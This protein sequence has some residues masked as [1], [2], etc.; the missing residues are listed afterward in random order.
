MTNARHHERIL[1]LQCD[2]ALE[3]LSADDSA[4][5]LALLQDA[6]VRNH[7]AFDLC[8]AALDLALSPACEEM[9]ASVRARCAAALDAACAL[10]ASAAPPVLASIGPARPTAAPRASNVR[11][12]G[13]AAAAIALASACV[14]ATILWQRSTDP[15]TRS[16]REVAMEL[17]RQGV[18]P[19]ALDHTE[20]PLATQA[21]AEILWD[22]TSQQGCLLVHGLE[23]NDP[24]KTQYQLWIFDKTRDE[25]FPVDGGVFDVADNGEAVVPIR[26]PVPVRDASLFAVTVEPPGGSVVSDRR[27]VLVGKR[28]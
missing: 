24:T 20:D 11:W 26:P 5:M 18:A 7:D 12:L 1:E 4:E 6:R 9:P 19:I 27:I 28:G 25:R 16:P 13:F 8:A 23:R 2:R 21:S 15:R 17:Q 3:G 14:W 10:E 22:P